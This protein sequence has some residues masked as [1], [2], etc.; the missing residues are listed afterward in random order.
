M[1]SE[2]IHPFDSI[3]SAHEFVALLEAS[4]VEAAREVQALLEPN[5]QDERRREALSLALYKMNQLAMHIQKSRRILNDLRSIRILLFK[6]R[7]S[8]G[9]A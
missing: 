6:E 1:K 2:S 7:A 4:I 9:S 8:G 3:E 5:E